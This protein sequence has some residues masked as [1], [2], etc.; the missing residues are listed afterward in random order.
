MNDNQPNYLLVLL[1]KHKMFIC[2]WLATISI[3]TKP[4]PPQKKAKKIVMYYICN[5]LHNII[6]IIILTFGFYILWLLVFST[7]HT[8]TSLELQ[9][10]NG[11][12]PLIY[13]F[14]AAKISNAHQ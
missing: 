2:K 3:A 12:L 11:L 10:L 6:I 4:P 7:E 8:K 9:P 14:L 13:T 5:I 1:P